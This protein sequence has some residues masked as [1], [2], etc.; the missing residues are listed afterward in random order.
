MLANDVYDKVHEHGHDPIPYDYDPDYEDDNPFDDDDDN[1]YDDDGYDYADE[2][3]YEY[4]HF[5]YD[6]DG[7]GGN[8]HEDVP[9]RIVG[10]PDHGANLK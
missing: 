8:D 4:P 6:Y 3:D 9:V 7:A 5:D 10:S 2:D 1:P